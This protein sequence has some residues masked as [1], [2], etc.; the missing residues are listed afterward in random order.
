MT[1]RSLGV[2][3]F[4]GKAGVINEKI[5]VIGG[6]SYN[7]VSF[8]DTRGS[9]GVGVS[10]KLGDSRLELECTVIDEEVDFIGLG[11]LF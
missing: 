5:E 8:S 3:Y 9:I 2:V 1:Y 7:D 6:P 11:Y 4:K 10:M